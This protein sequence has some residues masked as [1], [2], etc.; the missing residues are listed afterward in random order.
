MLHYLYI[1]V[2]ILSIIL[3]A[4]RDGHKCINKKFNK[5]MD[6]LDWFVLKWEEL[7]KF[8]NPVPYNLE[9]ENDNFEFFAGNQFI[10]LD[11]I[12]RYTL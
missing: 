7:A 11:R 5:E 1:R 6:L 2:L 4:F 12:D 10:S 8:W 3:H 9:A